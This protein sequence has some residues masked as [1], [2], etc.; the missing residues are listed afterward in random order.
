LTEAAKEFSSKSK[1]GILYW[2]LAALVMLAAAVYQRRAGPTYPLRGRTSVGGE[3]MAFRLPRSA[4]NT[5]AAKITIPDLGFQARLL[6]RRY[7]IEEPFT[8][9]FFAPGVEGSKNIL[10]AEIPP[11]D[12][13]GKVEYKIEV[14]SQAIPDDEETVILRFKGPVSAPLLIS[15]IL[16]ML[17]GM[18]ASTRAGIG[19]AFGRVEKTLPWA[20]LGMIAL[21][22]LVLG[23]FVQKEAFGAYWTGW[24]FGY[25]L[26]DNKTM[27]MFLA[28]LAASL[29]TLHPKARRPAIVAASLLTIVVYLVPH[30]LRGSQLDYRQGT[31][32]T[33]K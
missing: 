20:A 2:L 13:A 19:A 22:G 12:A 16:T 6:W 29:L 10:T 9:A 25:D 4:E 24:P 18:L 15:H 30:S 7:P 23:P 3:Q 17:V 8:V 1:L 31:V 14:A 33:G 21:G 28:W 32:Q 5:S 26:T 11:H 27:L